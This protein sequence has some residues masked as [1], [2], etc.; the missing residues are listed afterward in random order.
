M[1]FGK[2]VFYHHMEIFKNL[3]LGALFLCNILLTCVYCLYIL[4]KDLTLIFILQIPS[5]QEKN[6][7]ICF[8]QCIIQGI[9]NYY[10]LIRLCNH[11]PQEDV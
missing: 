3:F 9:M 11:V 6:S 10:M 1:E 5:G 8:P 2:Y 4:I 7:I